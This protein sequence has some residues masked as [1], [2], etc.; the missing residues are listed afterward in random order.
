MTLSELLKT[1]RETIN[2]LEIAINAD[3]TLADIRALDEQLLV[4][5]SAI[6]TLNLTDAADI[7]TQLKFF[8]YQ[9]NQNGIDQPL[10]SEFKSLETLIERYAD[11]LASRQPE[12]PIA[13]E[14]SV[15][16]STSEFATRDVIEASD[17]RV[18]FY[19]MDF[20][21]EYTSQANAKFHNASPSEFRGRHVIDVIGERRFFERAKDRFEKCFAGHGQRYSYYLDVDGKGRRLMDC[22]IK[23]HRCADA[24]VSGALLAVEDI[25][26][27]VENAQLL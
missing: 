18:S 15:C 3:A 9:A 25:T 7:E 8:L 20:Q 2:R 16:L 21:Y 1:H 5:V 24:K 6:E 27:R 17:V 23:P 26:D 13:G 12:L 11:R 4:A 10:S 19:N 14:L 22:H